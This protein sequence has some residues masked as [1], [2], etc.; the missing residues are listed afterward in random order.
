MK[1]Y[2]FKLN[3]DGT[4]N[5]SLT[6]HNMFANTNC[7]GKPLQDRLPELARIVN[8]KID[9]ENILTPTPSEG[10]DELVRRYHNGSTVEP[11]YADTNCTNK[12]GSLD[13]Y[14]QCDCFGTFNNRAMV[15]YKVDGSN[16]YK[17]GFV[18]WLGGVK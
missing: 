9:G 11:V 2:N 7:P 8:E 3:Y 1:R 5:G 4:K 12:V 17:I 16:N 10:S 13:R 15:R 14:E 18:K 6:R